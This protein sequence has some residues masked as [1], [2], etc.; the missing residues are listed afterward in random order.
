MKS[1]TVDK[2]YWVFIGIGAFA[3]AMLYSGVMILLE[4][5]FQL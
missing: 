4:D 3:L 2:I 1:S 5:A